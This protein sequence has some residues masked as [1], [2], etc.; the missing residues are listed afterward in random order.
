MAMKGTFERN[1]LPTVTRSVQGTEFAKNVRTY[2][3]N[4]YYNYTHRVGG[5][6]QSDAS[7]Q[8]RRDAL[9]QRVRDRFNEDL[10]SEDLNKRPSSRHMK[11][12]SKIL[13]A[14]DQ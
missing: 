5:D 13:S 3:P 1:G 9:G 4:D 11:L 8:V 7:S 6:T 14:C 12:N 10:T 2:K